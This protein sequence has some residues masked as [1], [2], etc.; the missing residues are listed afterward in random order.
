MFKN[1]IKAGTKLRIIAGG[2]GDIHYH[3]FKHGSIV[4]VEEDST[5]DGSVL[6]RGDCFFKT[7]EVRRNYTQF[8]P[9]EYFEVVEV[10]L[11]APLFTVEGTPVE[12]ITTSGR[13]KKFPVLAYEGKAKLPSKYTLQGISKSGEARRNLINVQ[14]VE[15]PSEQVEDKSEEVVLYANLYDDAERGLQQLDIGNELYTS[16]E[17]A[18]ASYKE[19]RI[20]SKSHPKRIGVAKVTLVKGKLPSRFNKEVK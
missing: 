14:V 20:E 7:G 5:D 2:V 6:A 13:D 17:E 10:D 18:T 19:G 15:E 11:T 3:N 16:V 4:T 1:F 12:L 8:V 9:Q